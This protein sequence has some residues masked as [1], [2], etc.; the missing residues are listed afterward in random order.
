MPSVFITG[1]NKGIG[2]EAVRFIASQGDHDIVIAGRTPT[3]MEAAATELRKLSNR[4]VMTVALDTSSMESVRRGAKALKELLSR[5]EI[6]RPS[7]LIF[8][9]G[10]QSLRAPEYTVDGFERTFATN[11]LGH[12]L[13]LNLLIDDVCD[14]GRVVWTA[15]G[16]HDPNTMD[17]K[18]VGGVAP[19]DADALASTGKS[20]KPLPGGVRYATSKLC[21]LLYSYELERR[22][23]AAGAAVSSIAYDPGFIADT[24]LGRTAPPFMQ[25]ISKTSFFRI[26]FGLLGGTVGDLAFSGEGLGRVAIASEYMDAGGKY[27]QSKN[28]HLKEARSSPASHSK[29]DAAKLWLASERLVRLQA[30]EQ[31]RRLQRELQATVVSD[32][33]KQV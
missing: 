13:L 28:H 30:G 31:A 25:W 12:F 10:M 7:S 16:T 17:G 26:M 14:G 11:C 18:V 23:R 6:S 2:L 19:P 24:G 32:N 33:T 1:A 21:T 4:S 5:R 29:E 8:N 15:S 3:E 22:L 9:A 27:V 20:G